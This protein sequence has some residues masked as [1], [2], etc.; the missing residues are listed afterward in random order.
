MEKQ[1][2]NNTKLI[3]NVKN[4]NTI[5]SKI[6][7]I[8]PCYN[9]KKELLE[10]CL[11]SLSNQSY[12]NYEIIIVDDGSKIPITEYFSSKYLAENN[13]FIFR[14]ENKG[15]SS[16]RNQ[17]VLL[18]TGDY[19]T[20]VDADDFVLP[21]FLEQSL[22]LSMLY[23]ADMVIGGICYVK[24]IEDYPDELFRE[25]IDN[26]EIIEGKGKIVDLSISVL[27]REIKFSNGYV[28]RGPIA[29]LLK[30]EI[31]LSTKFP[32]NL[33]YAE[34]SI[35]N[36]EIIRKCKKVCLVRHTW[37]LYVEN[38]QS[39]N[40]TKDEK[41]FIGCR[42]TLNETKKYIDFSNDHQNRVYGNRVCELIQFINDIGFID[43][44][45]EH[46]L[47]TK[48]PWTILHEKK[49]F[50]MTD[51]KHKLFCVAYNLRVLFPLLKFHKFIKN[52]K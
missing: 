33:T 6:S 22:N 42:D 19:I 29:R 34:D 13:I 49:Y 41:V 40:H 47:Y 45:V 7:V 50:Q 28:G 5:S 11:D 9:T 23:D 20:F 24:A 51:L 39:I 25:K 3:K 14:Q 38:L 21:L 26:F 32:E 10:R 44:K 4:N 30:R 52:I 37:Y 35:W 43:K 15:A 2:N 16:A 46:D 1:I 31:A 36:L 12:M 8:I 27:G 17:G 48:E 18:S